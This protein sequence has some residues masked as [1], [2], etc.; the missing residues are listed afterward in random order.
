MLPLIFTCLAL[1]MLRRRFFY[2][3][4]LLEAFRVTPPPN[5]NAVE[6]L[7]TLQ[8]GI[9]QLEALIQAGNIVLLKIRALLFAVVPQACYTT[10]CHFFYMNKKAL[11]TSITSSNPRCLASVLIASVWFWLIYFYKIFWRLQIELLNNRIWLPLYFD[12]I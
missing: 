11:I 1:I 4:Q 8:D 5:R 2:R 12:C 9:S 6:Q 7:L 3:G 10:Q